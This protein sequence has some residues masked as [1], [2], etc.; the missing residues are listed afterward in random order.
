MNRNKNVIK[1]FMNRGFGGD[2]ITK[3][4]VTRAIEVVAFL[5]AAFGH[6]LLNI[7]PPN[8]TEVSFAV[9]FASF[10]SVLALLFISAKSNDLPRKKHRKRWLISVIIALVIAAISAPIYQYV[11]LKYTFAVD[12]KGQ[13]QRFIRG[14]ELTPYAKKYMEN[15]EAATVDQLVNDTGKLSQ[16]DALWTNKSII[17]VKIKLTVAYVILVLS[18]MTAIFCIT[19]GLLNKP[20]NE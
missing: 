12:I 17:L 19:E 18:I 6:F 14:T 15:N 11:F 4:F 20:K 1:K 10:F 7:A 13:P 16:L 9:G 8:E 3:T 5:F 2:M